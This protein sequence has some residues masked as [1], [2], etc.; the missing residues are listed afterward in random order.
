MALQLVVVDGPDLG[1]SF[2][3]TSHAVVGRD[4]TAFVH[5]NDERVSRRHA[6]IS[7]EGE[8]VS[9]EDLG[10]SNG[11]WIGDRQVEGSA[12]ISLG[13]RVRVGGTTLELREGQATEDQTV[14]G[15][16]STDPPATKV[17]LPALGDDP[18]PEG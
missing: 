12:T 2:D 16:A 11:T 6:I 7:A 18:P 1:R 4:P 17:P 3:V 13:E 9:V 14:L 8:S 15:G 5:L 10:S